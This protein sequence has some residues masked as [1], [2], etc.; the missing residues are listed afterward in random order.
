MHDVIDA[1]YSTDV[2]DTVTVCN[3]ASGVLNA[4]VC[5]SQLS[6][7]ADAGKHHVLQP[8]SVQ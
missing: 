7:D 4:C 1:C 6:E 8:Y 5:M 2:H 3:Y